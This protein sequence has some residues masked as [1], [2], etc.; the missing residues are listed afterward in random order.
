M[1]ADNEKLKAEMIRQA[2]M[3]K[4]RDN[5]YIQQH[6]KLVEEQERKRKEEIDQRNNLIRLRM[7]KMGGQLLKDHQDK[8]K[9]EDKILLN[10]VR[11]KEAKEILEE[12]QKMLELKRYQK[13]LR[14]FLA[15]QVNAHNRSK[16]LE[17]EKNK[18]F[19][20][21]EMEKAKQEKLKEQEEKQ[22][23]R[24]KEMENHKFITDQI[25]EKQKTGRGDKIGKYGSNGMNEAEYRFNRDLLLGINGKKKSME[26]ELKEFEDPKASGPE[27]TYFI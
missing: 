5:E 23:R 18:W 12:N 22:K 9:A 6:N 24:L 15:N 1:I 17:Q 20:N 27:R 10:R 7:E 19:I 11:E 13:D 3:E 25:A 4:Q 8:E 16:A 14:E 21:K 26:R 2:K